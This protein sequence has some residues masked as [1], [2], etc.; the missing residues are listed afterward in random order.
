MEYLLIGKIVSTH[1]IKGEIKIISDFQFKEKVFTKGMKLYIGKEKKEEQITS[2]RKHKNYDM[3]TLEGYCDINQVLPFMR[4]EV[5][6]KKEDVKL[7]EDEY[8]DSS[9]IGL[10]IYNGNELL[11]TI[12]EVF[13]SSPST[14]LIRFGKDGKTFLVPYVKNFVKTIDLSSKKVI[15]YSMEGVLECE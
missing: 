11:G 10:N 14:K 3:V 6:C 12:T 15:L 1:G 7:E 8:L 9:L 5:Y 4:K 2:Y 13:Y